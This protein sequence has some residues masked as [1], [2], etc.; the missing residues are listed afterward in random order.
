MIRVCGD[1]PFV[2]ASEID[3][4]LSEHQDNDAVYTTNVGE[5]MPRDTSVDVVDREV[6]DDLTER[7]E[8]H[9][10]IPLREQTDRW[11][12]CVSPNPELARF[13]SVG[14]DIDTPAEYWQLVDAIDAVGSDPFAVREYLLEER[15][16]TGP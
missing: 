5:G 12:A 7:G 4:V 8:T 2:L 14:T 13:Q 9:P 10:V 6:L 15:E 1:S 3:R 16:E 11:D